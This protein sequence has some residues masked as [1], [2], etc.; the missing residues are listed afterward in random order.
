M[1]WGQVN[2]TQCKFIDYRLIIASLLAVLRY[3]INMQNIN[4]NFLE[5]IPCVA[6]FL[7]VI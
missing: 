7:Q 3:L 6:S 5:H 4:E 2:Q 1:I